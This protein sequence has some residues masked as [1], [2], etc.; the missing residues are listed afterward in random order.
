MRKIFL[1]IAMVFVLG[2]V[3]AQ[4]VDYELVG[5]VNEDGQVLNDWLLGASE[6]LNVRVQLKNNG[7]DMPASSD[8][9]I[10]VVKYNYDSI[11]TVSVAGT[12]L[13]SILPGQAGTITFPQPLFTAAAMDQ[14]VMTA[15]SLCFEM[16][17]E[18]TATDPVSA[19]NE[20]CVSV[21]RPLPVEENELMSIRIYPNPVASVCT[22][23]C[24]VA[25]TT[26]TVV[27]V[28]DMMGRKVATAVMDAEIC[29]LDMSGLAAGMY[30]L[31]VERDGAVV[32]TEKLMKE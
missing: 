12:E 6:D 18:G 14:Y 17:L 7:P 30:V 16:R 26:S 25:P 32:A 3:S 8:R 31:R 28:Y 22:V 4:Q 19:N 29:T 27:S 15:F 23:D 20:A 11:G 9:L 13:Q 10:F 2:C 5:F 24:G 1:F 21:C